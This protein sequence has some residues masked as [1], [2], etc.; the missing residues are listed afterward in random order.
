MSRRC[1]GTGAAKVSEYTVNLAMRRW[2]RPKDDKSPIDG[3]P[4]FGPGAG[5]DVSGLLAQPPEG[6]DPRTVSSGRRRGAAPRDRRRR[7]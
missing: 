5:E 4:T 2:T 1:Y 3:R 7:R 6:L